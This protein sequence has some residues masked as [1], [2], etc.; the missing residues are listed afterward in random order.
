[1]GKILVNR[2]GYR[3]VSFGDYLRQDVCAKH[4]LAKVPKD[5]R[6]PLPDFGGRNFKGLMLD[7]DVEIAI[8]DP[9]RYCRKVYDEI[10]NACTSEDRNFVITDLRKTIEL[11]TI[12]KMGLP[13]YL[14]RIVR[15]GYPEDVLRMDD[16]LSTMAKFHLIRNDAFPNKMVAGLRE[17]MER[18][19][20]YG[21][22]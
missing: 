6:S 18:E 4:N 19:L 12:L 21:Y 3:R 5:E 8:A 10:T 7:L 2:Y 13:V 14:I 17:I 20:P 15:P 22:E 16:L 1:L 11:K 9:F